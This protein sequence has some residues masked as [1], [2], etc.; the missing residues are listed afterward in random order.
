MGQEIEAKFYL[1]DQPGMAA[2]LQALGAQLIQPRTH[3]LNLRFD[4]PG[5]DFQ[6][7][8]RVL[9]LRQD[10]A[11]RLTYKDGATLEDGAFS[12]REIEFVV[13]DFDWRG[14]SSKPLAMKSFSPT[15]NTDPPMS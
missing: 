6:R 7:Q 15:K 4:T 14:N 9:R 8:R 11:S 1:S 5:R 2:R 10:E 13:G 12:R 3:E